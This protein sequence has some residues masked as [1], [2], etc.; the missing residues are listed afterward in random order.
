MTAHRTNSSAL[1]FL[2]AAMEVEE[3][4]PSP[5]G[6]GIIWA[7]VIFFAV[8]VAWACVGHLDIVSVAHG[9]IIPSGRVKVIQ[10]L[11]S[12]VVSK[13]LVADG[14]TVAAGDVLLE[15]DTTVAEAE[16]QRLEEELLTVELD[17][18]R[19]RAILAAVA[20]G[21]VSI[22]SPP[23][24]SS[25]QLELQESRLYNAYAHYQAS[26]SALRQGEIRGRAEYGATQS[27]IAQLSATIP[28]T[29]EQAES[30]NQLVV[31]QLAARTRWLDLERERIE[32]VK[33]RDIQ[34][35]QLR[36][37]EASIERIR[38]NR[39]VYN[40]Q[41][42]AEHLEELSAS[43]MRA[44][45]LKKELIKA[46]Q[47]NTLQHLR[48]PIA[49]VVQQLAV[50]TIGGVVTPAQPV[51]V[52]VPKDQTL[53]AEAWVKNR[54]VGFVNRAQRAEIKVDAFPFTR[55]G[56]IDGEIVN[57]SSDAVPNEEL[58]PVYVAQVSLEKSSILVEG[59]EVGLAPGMAITVEVRTGERRLIEFLLSPLLKGLKESA[60]ER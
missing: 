5:A 2:P 44:T 60:R 39:V 54:D 40:A 37:I 49:G 3:T 16:Q 20:T 27:R 57:L 15:L 22:D 41:F 17:Q 13:I 12:G 52:I 55:Y 21:T 7:I 50:H 34:R 6:R 53:L 1:E 32:Q 4:P 29:T 9:K 56:T 8:A 30:V 31:Q 14:Q 46:E 33:E 42:E 11:E 36:M 48:T 28:L 59:K 47:R 24:V 23:G 25:A 38:Q 43:E 58:G 26:I 19:I 18:A 35:H 10:P 51:M 45:S